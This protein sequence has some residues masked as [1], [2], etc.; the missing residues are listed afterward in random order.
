M[1]MLYREKDR[2]QFVNWTVVLRVQFDPETCTREEL[3]KIIEAAGH[4]VGIGFGRP[5]HGGP[6]GTWEISQ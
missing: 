4:R 6:L 5:G 3:D 1:T 2:T